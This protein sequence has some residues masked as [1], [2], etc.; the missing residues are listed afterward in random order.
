MMGAHACADFLSELFGEPVPDHMV[1][2]YID[3]GT[4]PGG[5]VAAVPGVSKPVLITSKSAIREH[6][7]KIASQL[8]KTAE[9]AV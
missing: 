8:A 1:Y 5:R 9:K 3:R 7:T 4:I 6:F 2:R